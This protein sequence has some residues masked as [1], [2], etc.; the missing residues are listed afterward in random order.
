MPTLK[1]QEIAHKNTDFQLS[2]ENPRLWPPGPPH[3]A[4]QLPGVKVRAALSRATTSFRLSMN[5]STAPTTL[6]CLLK[7]VGA[8]VVI[9]QHAGTVVPRA[10]G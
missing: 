3:S 5:L 4:W 10:L 8:S 6:C 1:N 2:L 7:M 9:C